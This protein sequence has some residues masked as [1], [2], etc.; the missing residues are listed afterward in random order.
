MNLTPPKVIAREVVYKL[1][2]ILGHQRILGPK[3]VQ[4]LEGRKGLKK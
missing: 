3:G 4:T 1:K 2:V